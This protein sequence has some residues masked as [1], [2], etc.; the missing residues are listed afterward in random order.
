MIESIHGAYERY[1]HLDQLLS[2]SEWMLPTSDSDADGLA[3]ILNTICHDLWM[4]VK[5]AAIEHEK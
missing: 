1:K 2:D 4:A 3:R 5:E